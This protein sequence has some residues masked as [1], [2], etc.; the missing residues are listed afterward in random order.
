MVKKWNLMALFDNRSADGGEDVDRGQRLYVAML[1][2][3]G[4]IVVGAIAELAT[5]SF[6]E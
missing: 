5:R 2:L 6:R 3:A 4:M 1:I